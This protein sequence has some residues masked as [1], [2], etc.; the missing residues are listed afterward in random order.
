M[1]YE[2]IVMNY[3]IYSIAVAIFINLLCVWWMWYIIS[4]TGKLHVLN[5]F[6]KMVMHIATDVA[7]VWPKYHV[8]PFRQAIK[9]YHYHCLLNPGEGISILAG[10]HLSPM[11]VPCT[12]MEVTS[13]NLSPWRTPQSYEGGASALWGYLGPRWNCSHGNPVLGLMCLQVLQ[14]WDTSIILHLSYIYRLV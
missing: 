13:W 6:V 1:W 2:L 9:G 8:C 3:N 5:N 11:R 14:S 4:V 10:G 12:Q 7:H